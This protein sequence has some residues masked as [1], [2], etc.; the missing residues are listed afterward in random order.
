MPPVSRNRH[1]P[2]KHYIGNV[3]SLWYKVSGLGP[4]PGWS[5]RPPGGPLP[6]GGGCQRGRPSGSGRHGFSARNPHPHLHIS[7]E[8]PFADLQN[9][10]NV[11]SMFEE[12]GLV[13]IVWFMVMK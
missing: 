9:E 6:S 5:P 10:R 4:L 12:T 8:C 1:S 3:S 2:D 11:V 7:A 13:L